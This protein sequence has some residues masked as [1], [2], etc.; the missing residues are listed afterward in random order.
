M[1]APVRLS[2]PTNGGLDLES[3]FGRH[4]LRLRGPAYSMAASDTDRIA[5]KLPTAP[6]TEVRPAHGLLRNKSPSRLAGAALFVAGW[7]LLFWIGRSELFR[8]PGTFWHLV[9]GQQMLR[10]GHVPRV[11]SFSFTFG[12]K[13]WES[14]WWLAEWAMAALYRAGGW[15]LL[16][17]VTVTLIAA[18]YAALGARLLATGLRVLPTLVVLGLVVAAGSPQ[19]HVRPLVVTTALL[20][21]TMALLVEIES[22]RAGVARLWWTVPVV[23]LWAN[24]HGGVLA[25]LGTIGLAVAGWMAAAWLG[26]RSPLDCRAKRLSAGAAVAASCAAVLAN[27]YGWDLVRG[28]WRILS[29]PLQDLIQEHARLSLREPVGWMVAGLA[30]VYGATLL[31][32]PRGRV[33]ITWLLPLVWLVLACQRVRNAQLFA[34]TA[35]V[36]WCEML[37]YSRLSSWLASRGLLTAGGSGPTPSA[38]PAARLAL[39]GSLGAVLLL[40]LGASRPFGP[41]DD[42]WV[43]FAPT[44]WPVELRGELARIQQA[45]PP[46]TPIFNDM[47]FG[48]FLIY[49][50]PRLR[51]FI[52]DRCELYG[53]PFLEEYDDARR[54]APARIDSW[55]R[56]FGFRYALVESNTPFD[57][58]LAHHPDWAQ[59]G[60]T[61]VA[62]LYGP[63]GEKVAR[64]RITPPGSSPAPDAA[65]AGTP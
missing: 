47:A 38:R 40:A 16:L 7:L 13:P 34:I 44:R 20:Y 45:E 15:D 46:G 31:A 4:A 57:R 39:R 14:Q 25:G 42:R 23:A 36:A 10:T 32:V 41:G 22:G 56:R 18:V 53:G 62:A 19:F 3:E 61:R 52:D 54:G 28:W 58:Y 55:R 60:R 43:R 9:V 27:P 37:P 30:A 65:R 8:D 17:L 21:A 49:H 29:M 6:S 59:L 33:R 24:C 63:P 11:D 2:R 51:V 64:A 50:A 48:G 26:C 12:G 1:R 5:G 35:A